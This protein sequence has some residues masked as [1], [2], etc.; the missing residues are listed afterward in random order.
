VSTVSKQKNESTPTRSISFLYPKG[1]SKK[2]IRRK[3]EIYY[4]DKSRCRK[5]LEFSDCKMPTSF[6][7]INLHI[8]W[9][10]GGL[11][12]TNENNSIVRQ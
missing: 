5:K 4:A 10:R 6:S 11:F 1:R 7:L 12:G 8:S 3:K 2:Q 9:C